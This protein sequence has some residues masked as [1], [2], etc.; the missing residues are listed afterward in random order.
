[1]TTPTPTIT[2][3]LDTLLNS[4]WIVE[5]DSSQTTTP[6]WVPVRGIVSLTLPLTPTMQDTGTFDSGHWAGSRKTELAWGVNMSILRGTDAEGEFDEGQE[7]IRIAAS[8]MGSTGI[9]HV[10]MYDRDGLPEAYEGYV[11]AS[12]DAAGGDKKGLETVNANCPGNGERFD[13]ENPLAA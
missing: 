5:V 7:I 13:I 9:L 2:R 12:W 8:K 10:R 11:D 6:A 3:P 4:R 1:M